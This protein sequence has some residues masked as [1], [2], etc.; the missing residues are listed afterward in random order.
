[1]PYD[2]TYMWNLKCDTSELIYEADSQTERTGLCLPEGAG[3]W[4]G[5]DW[6]FEISRCK[7]LYIEWINNKV[8]LGAGSYIPCPVINHDGKECEKC[9]YS[10][11]ESL[12]CTAEISTLQ[13][14]YTS[15]K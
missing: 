9:I 14:N 15:I 11:T 4:D 5:K 13:I 7:L 12:C 3:G 6:E 8:L 10:I 1:M 2:I